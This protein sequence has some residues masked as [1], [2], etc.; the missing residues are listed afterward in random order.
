MRFRLEI[1]V[2][3]ETPD[4]DAATDLAHDAWES[5]VA[6]VGVH[7]IEDPD[8]FKGDFCVEGLDEESANALKVYDE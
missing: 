5:A 7:K 4:A 2:T 3:V 1:I 8:P 6:L